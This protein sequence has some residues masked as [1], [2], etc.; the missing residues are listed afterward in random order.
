MRP[1]VQDV[2]RVQPDFRQRGL[3]ALQLLI[4]RQAVAPH[5][6]RIRQ[7]TTIG[8]EL[9]ERGEGIL[10]D[11]LHLLPIDLEVIGV[12]KLRHI[13]PVK[14]DVATGR[15]Q[16][17]QQ[18]PGQGRLATSALADDGQDLTWLYAERHLL[19]QFPFAPVASALE[20][21]QPLFRQ[22]GVRPPHGSLQREFSLMKSIS[23]SNFANARPVT[24]SAPP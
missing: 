13:L 15:V 20:Q 10:K 4:A 24:V 8:V 22:G 2:G 9:V 7:D 14:Q 1:L 21:R 17:P 23:S 18:E 6:Q 19:P 3:D 5:I 12:V 11:S 16:Q